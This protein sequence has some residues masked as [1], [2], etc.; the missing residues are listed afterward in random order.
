VTVIQSDVTVDWMR[1]DSARANI[2]RHIKRLLRKYAYPPDLQDAA[3]Q[4]VL[5]QAEALSA[6][7]AGAA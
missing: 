4:N 3:V 1:R 5:Q 7:W 2:P 6:E